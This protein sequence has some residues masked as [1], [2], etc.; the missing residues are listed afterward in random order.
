MQTFISR[1]P[2][3]WAKI[4][5]G[6]LA[7]G[8]LFTGAAPAAVAD[9]GGDGVEIDVTIPGTSDSGLGSEDLDIEDAQFT[10][11]INPES[12]SGAFFGGCNF[13]MAGQAGDVGSSKVWSN[14]EGKDMY[15][16]KDG[17]VSLR[18]LNAQGNWTTPTWDTK[19]LDP[20]GRRV[21]SSDPAANHT[22]T[23][24]VIDGGEGQ[25]DASA[26]ELTIQWEGT[27][28]V[29]YYG[30]M[31]YWWA[32]DP[33]LE[34]R[35]NS[36]GELVGEVTAQASGYGADMFDTTKWV[37]LGE[38][39]I[40]LATFGEKSSKATSAEL[41]SEKGDLIGFQGR[42]DYEGV[43][44]NVEAGGPSGAQNRT[45][46]NWGSFPQDF[47]DFQVETGQAAYW[48]TSGGLRD[49][50]KPPSVLTVS[51]DSSRLVGAGSTNR[52]PAV[53][54]EIVQPGQGG[55]GLT[56]PGGSTTGTG[57][58]GPPTTILGGASGGSYQPLDLE[59]LLAALSQE[60]GVPADA[61]DLAALQTRYGQA[62]EAQEIDWLGTGLI[63]EGVRDFFNQHRE[64]FLYSL[65]G[66]LG[67][68]AL[69]YLAFHRGWLVLP[70]TNKT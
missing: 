43:A 6:L 36:A 45:L 13:L 31:T 26:G 67:L 28:S 21:L 55:E 59:A 66:L 49:L 7:L 14:A 60:H 37:E 69:T 53:P 23:E 46:A 25:Y 27:F 52:P 22:E 11:G 32:T 19:C 40:T 48:Y 33:V 65:A 9:T 68:G 64:P 15:S 62:L 42:P 17:N 51:F 30:G 38:S 57:T 1:G 70:W 44:I 8:F 63:P 4:G 12:N 24:V 50:A 16:T 20:H 58:I 3:S 10:W 29:V 47:I 18:K 61:A 41:V 35:E 56:G 54:D 39:T 2:R 34:L 5:A